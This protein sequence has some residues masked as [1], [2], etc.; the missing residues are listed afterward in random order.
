MK[1]SLSSYFESDEFLELLSSYENMS[2]EGTPKYFDGLDLSNIAEFYSSMDDNDRAMEAIEFGLR[3]HPGDADILTSK[4]QILL[5]QGQSDEARAIA[6]TIAD[7]GDD[8]ELLFLKGSIELF[9]GNNELADDYFHQAVTAEEEDPGLYADI[10][11]LFIDYAQY[12]YAQSWL[13]VA[14]LL[15]SDSNEFAEQQADL[16][17]A[18]QDYDKATEAYDRLIDNYPYDVYYWE[19]LVCIAYRQE[20][21]AKALEYFEYIEAIDPKHDSMSMIKVE[22]LLETDHY[23]QAEKLLR[24]II[25]KNPEYSDALFLLGN[26]LSLQMKHEEAIPY[27]ERAIELNGD[28]K[29]MYIQLAG[30]YYECARYK[31]SAERLTVALRAGFAPD[32]DTIRAL[33]YPLLQNDETDIIFDLLE[34]LLDIEDINMEEYGI[35]LPAITMCCWQMG[36]TE[37]FKRYFEWL[38][39]TNSENALKLFGITDLET[40]KEDAVRLLMRVYDKEKQKTETR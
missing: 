4:G 9:D 23:P 28:D 32:A 30:E 36:L 18:T 26:A 34:A 11:A 33:I 29:Q 24:N 25:R 20:K 3:L 22:C 5:R 27:I 6:D 1:E 7:N 19:Q 38:Y 8:R 17:F 14:R 15:E 13:D 12:D 16:Y 21:W 37:K 35:F 2:A 31:E 10:I 40:P 39:D